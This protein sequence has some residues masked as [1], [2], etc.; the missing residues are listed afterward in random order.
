MLCG[1]S[2]YFSKAL[3]GSFR[4]AQKKK[5]AF[6]EDDPEGF[7]Y[8]VSFLY[9][10]TN[11]LFISVHGPDDISRALKFYVFASKICE[12]GLQDAIITAVYDKIGYTCENTYLRPHHVHYIYQNTTTGDRMRLL[13]SEALVIGTV[14]VTGYTDFLNGW[15]MDSFSAGE[16]GLDIIKFINSHIKPRSCSTL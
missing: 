5:I 2:D 14:G 16:F 7:A 13:L 9:N 15:V 6:P 8:Y 3:Q 11:T 1:K 4:E 12:K 10:P